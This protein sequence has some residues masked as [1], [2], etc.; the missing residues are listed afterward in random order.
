MIKEKKVTRETV[1]TVYV[2][3]IC[4]KERA[5]PYKK[6]QM[7][8]KDIC[9]NC[10]VITYELGDYNNRYCRSCWNTGQDYIKEIKTIRSRST[11]L[12]ERWEKKAK[13]NANAKLHKGV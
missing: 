3:D 2:C 7:C 8:G 10:F 6:C 12:Y 5:K 11:A 9:R 4:G 13:E 1:E